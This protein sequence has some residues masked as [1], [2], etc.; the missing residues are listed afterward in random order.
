MPFAQGRN[1]V[2]I[3]QVELTKL[4]AKD[5]DDNRY[6]LV[7]KGQEQS[8]ATMDGWMFINSNVGKDGKSN[9]QRTIETL[10]EIGLQGG[11]LM[12]L[13]SLINRECIFVCDHESSESDYGIET[14][15]PLRVQYIN[16]VREACSPDEIA[17]VMA[18]FSGG[19]M[20]NSVAQIQ[21][22]PQTQ[23]KPPQFQPPVQ[24]QA[25]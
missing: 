1:R 2:K 8:G 11:N 23:M 17:A 5:G 15:G 4:K 14:K 16:A 7:I 10:T 19:S 12:E 24:N 21:T 22:Q 20:P 3:T 25:I 9:Y 18:H 13:A 6:G